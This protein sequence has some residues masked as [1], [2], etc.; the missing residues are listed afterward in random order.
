MR[1]M[2]PLLT[3]H[4]AGELSSRQ[5]RND[6]NMQGHLSGGRRPTNDNRC[7]ACVADRHC[8]GRQGGLSLCFN[9]RSTFE[10]S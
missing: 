4:R 10:I 1:I 2:C 5:R 7:S 6:H 3:S 9:I 8:S